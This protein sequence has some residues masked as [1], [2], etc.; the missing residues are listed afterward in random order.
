MLRKYTVAM[1]QMDT[2]NDKG[3]NLKQAC[4]WID[5]AAAR[6]AKL[7][8]FP[9]VMNLIGRN[10]GEGGGKE[11]IPGYTTE[12]LCRKAKEHGVYIQGGS[13][14]EE[15]PGERRSSNISVLI[16]PKGEILAS[17]RKLHMFD[18][19]LA[20]GTPFKE[21][22]K[23]RPGDEIVTVET[24]LG[25]FGM[26][27]CYDVRFPELY[28]IMALRGAQ[29]IFVP[30]S[31]TMPTGKDHWEPLLRARAIENGCYIVA[32]GQIGT[33]PAYVAYG[34]SLVVDPWGTVIARAKDIPGITYAEID[35]DYLDKIRAQI[36]SLENRRTDLYE[37]VEKKG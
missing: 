11:Q 36:P 22:D 8:C 13:I 16:S 20:D 5:E 12:I 28:R 27:I 29:V 25:T 33:K 24:E 6:G 21:S 31:F 26:S 18:I 14:T 3:E 7:I 19:T 34:N 37:V 15:N 17:Y 30:A 35:L 32:T 2:Q 10:V 1:L 9:E 23:V 4:A